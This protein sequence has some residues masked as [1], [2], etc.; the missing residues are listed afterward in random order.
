MPEMSKILIAYQIDFVRNQS[1][2]LLGTRSCNF[3]CD[4]AE[5]VSAVR[6]ELFMILFCFVLNECHLE[7]LD[8]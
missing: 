5:N 2:L 4:I 1:F 3:C 6:M 7:V 8:T